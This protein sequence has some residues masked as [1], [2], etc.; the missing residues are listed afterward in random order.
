[1]IISKA[2]QEKTA[3]E[4]RKILVVSLHKCGTHLIKNI[5]SQVGLEAQLVGP[6]CSEAHFSNLGP[7]EY[8]LS[9]Y[10]PESVDVYG[11][12]ETHRI[13]AVLNYRD[14]R[15]ACV[16]RFHWHHPSNTKVTNLPRE[17]MKKVYCSRFD[18][19]EELLASII[20]GEK[21]LNIEM[22][23]ADGFRLAR[24]LF[25]HPYVHKTRFEDL[26]G[27]KGGGSRVSQV[28]AISELLRFLRVQADAERVADGAFSEDAET[29]HRGQI[30]A[31][32]E[33]FTPRITELF[34]SL[35]GDIL[36]DYGYELVAATS[37]AAGESLE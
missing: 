24:G 32:E 13:A 5:L 15:D 29:F 27:P 31:H 10:S 7:N 8:L 17:F 4:T 37:R 25:L 18:S 26:I 36:R 20:K 23:F 3:M 35:H 28:K 2:R 12:I 34:N 33:V 9:H 22:A 14:P 1:M 6:E 30:G 16:S 11:L 21:F 19:D